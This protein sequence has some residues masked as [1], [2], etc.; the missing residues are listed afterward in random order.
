MNK[1]A[2][3]RKLRKFHKWPGIVITL[4]VILFSLSGILMNHRELISSID[5]KRSL[6]PTEYSYENWNKGAVKSVFRLSGDSTL[7]YGNIG[8]WLSTDHCQ[9]FQDWNTGFPKG[10]DNRKVNKILKTPN[11][12]LFAGTYF[13]LFQYSYPAHRW[14]KT[15]LPVSE[16]RITDLILKQNELL[17]QTRSF[18]LKS[19]D[20]VSFYPLVIPAPEGYD[21]KASL[22][23][24]LWLLHSG[25]IWGSVGKLIVDLFGLVILLISFTGL[26]HFIFPGWLKRRRER[27]KDNSKLAS[28][29]NFNLK[30][31]NR[32]GWIFIPFLIFVSITGMFLRPPLLIAIGNA[33]VSPIPGT[34]LSS[35]NPW[36]DK[37]RRVLYD[38]Q[39]HIFMFSTYDGIFFTDE[40]LKEP[41][42]RLP[43]EPPVSVMGCN[44]L[45]KKGESTYLIGSF[46]GLFLWEPLTG[47]VFD[48][49]SGS[50]YQAPQVA[51]PPVSKDMIDGWFSDS[52]GKEFYFDYNHGVLPIRNTTSFG[53]MSA[54]IIQESPISLWNLSLEIH[55][56]R[57]FEPILGMFYILYVPLAG[58]CILIVLISGFFIWWI[59]YRKTKLS[60]RREGTK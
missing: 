56:G 15:E 34:I 13:G 29:R 60:Q 28:A 49:L 14:I 11:G 36:Y 52:S 47:Q 58:L 54:E 41:M 53:A 42:R 32:L 18:L 3:L 30:W 20:G 55:T 40:N 22:F 26:L 57:I 16:E 59:G 37:L 21:G 38:E 45:E 19:S 48:Y 43:G 1:N 8:V 27:K 46:N 17:V 10:S 9:T 39:Q 24:T 5:I 51:G 44:V 4:F 50:P 33:T 12:K 6:L 35:P 2:I 23:K 25:E 31:H 7:V